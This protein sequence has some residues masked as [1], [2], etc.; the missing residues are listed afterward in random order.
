MAEIRAE[1]RCGYAISFVETDGE[2]WATVTPKTHTCTAA[3]KKTPPYIKEEKA[4]GRK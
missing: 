4:N 2:W 3:R 1:S